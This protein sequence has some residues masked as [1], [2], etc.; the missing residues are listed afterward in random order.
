[1]KL[2]QIEQIE[3]KELERRIRYRVTLTTSAGSDGVLA[4][5]R[6]R[7]LAKGC[8]DDRSAAL[9]K[10]QG[11]HTV[12]RDESMG[13]KGSNASQ[14]R[15]KHPNPLSESITQNAHIAGDTSAHRSPHLNINMNG[16][17]APLNKPG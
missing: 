17:V 12:S 8:R 10:G 11:R 15:L 4:N 1:M 3:E 6:K 9:Q 13:G 16:S 7:Q 14:D 5:E 2:D